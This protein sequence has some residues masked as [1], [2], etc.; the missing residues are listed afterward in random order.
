[1]LSCTLPAAVRRK[2]G[3]A[4]PGSGGNTYQARGRLSVSDA[5]SA[6]AASALLSHGCHAEVRAQ[7]CLVAR[8]LRVAGYQHLHVKSSESSEFLILA[9]HSD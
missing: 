9:T 6:G 1:M 8:F 2:A 5:H 3:G 7:T 4:D